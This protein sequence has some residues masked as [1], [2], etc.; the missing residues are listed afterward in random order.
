MSP[1]VESVAVGLSVSA[2]K[3]FTA[4][5]VERLTTRYGLAI[6]M[7]KEL[8][9]AAPSDA[10]E[11]KLLDAL[12][13]A[14]GNEGSL[15]T[16]SENALRDLANTGLLD[17]LLNVFGS[18]LSPEA[19]LRLVEYVHLSRGS[20]DANQSKKFAADIAKCLKVA[21]EEANG[22]RSAHSAGR[23]A[24]AK[25]RADLAK[26][27]NASIVGTID[28]L[29][30]SEGNWL[31]G[32]LFSFDTVAAEITQSLEPLKSYAKSLEATLN[33]VDVHG[34]SGDVVR[35]D[36]DDVYV[37]VPVFLIPR[38]GNFIGY[39]DLRKDLPRAR[40]AKGWQDTFNFV[41][42][43][44]LLGD[45]GGGKSTLSKKMCL[46]AARSVLA[47]GT[48]LPIL[49]NLRTYI[50]EAV[51][52]ER[53][54]LSSY[55]I[56]A[57]TK[58]LLDPADSELE[59]T[60]L[61]HLRVGAAFLVAD[62]LDEVLTPSNRSKV[63]NE[64]Q[65]L[66]RE[67]PLLPVLVTSRYVG[68]E[69]N[70]L[71]GFT[72]LGVDHLEDEAIGQIYENVSRSVLQRQKSIDAAAKRTFLAD[73]SRKAAELIRNPLLLTLIVIIHSKKSEIPDNRADLY[74]FC[75][76][77]LFE[78]WDSYR[79]I[80][81]V[82]P[83]RYRLFDLFKHLASVLYEREEYGGRISKIDLDRE[84]REFFRRDY[85]DNREG[86]A[87]EAAHHMVQHLTGRA[88]ILHEVGE[89]IFEFTHRTF[90]EFFYARHLETKNEPTESLIQE[91]VDLIRHGSRT[92]PAH[93]ALQMRTKD[94][95][96]ASTKVCDALRS[97]ISEDF[98]NVELL[99]FSL[100][101]LGYVLP[102]ASSLS[103]FVRTTAP[104]ALDS[105][106]PGPL[107]ALL[108]TT[109]PMR[110]TILEA[111]LPFVEE[112][113]PVSKIQLL[114]PALYRL[115]DE[116][117]PDLN[118]N[119]LR[120][121]VIDA[122]TTRS[123]SRQGTSPFLC[124]LAFDLGA[125]VNWVAMEKFGPRVWQSGE[126]LLPDI[127]ADCREMFVEA[128][129]AAS[130][131]EYVGGKYLRLARSLRKNIGAFSARPRVFPF[132]SSQG[133]DERGFPVVN[134]NSSTWIQ[135]AA[136]LETLALS[137]ALFLETSLDDIPRPQAQ[138]V[139]AAFRDLVDLLDVIKSPAFTTFHEWFSGERRFI[140][141]H[142]VAHRDLRNF[143]AD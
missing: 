16:V 27:A 139:R 123:F 37:D 96:V 80:T 77:L 88:W 138:R 109:S 25:L 69:T 39:R 97:A 92:I 95:R 102:E 118:E 75:A 106:S 57:V 43:T 33:S 81:P 98:T 127:L 36:L 48:Q 141:G 8:T 70:P 44:V 122:V 79:H 24:D 35:A 11:T 113:L 86:K 62:G 136:A 93:L 114:A 34:S 4:K 105:D 66:T 51:E 67:F 142:S 83:E 20:T 46:E 89:G 126:F 85:I 121:Q 119:D 38:E 112:A 90:L 52:D 3:A 29:I 137:M 53:L 22:G 117:D 128:S 40:V 30:D 17:M 58:T 61:Y 143:L 50:A 87:A 84:A 60:V 78:R 47:G 133:L 124:K 1:I 129:Q 45:P 68:Y 72:H 99:E 82:L 115:R 54:S 111:M 134:L 91:C 23:Q 19:G 14:I 130:D 42:K 21:F 71:V 32:S 108:C 100:D 5:V 103:N 41:T 49:V 125:K 110:P 104:L 13:R 76:D 56:G 94:K 74:S 2:V 12:Q 65:K 116:L 132:F 15:T 59:S 6:K 135:D 64:I 107:V 55:V 140:L 7:R 26:R 31:R 63:V 73:A 10:L 120:W 101:T 131:R 9:L 18:E 28:G